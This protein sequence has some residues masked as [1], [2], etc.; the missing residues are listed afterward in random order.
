MLDSNHN[1]TTKKELKTNIGKSLL[2][3]ETSL[4]G[5]EYISNGEVLMV[6]PCAHTKRKWFA[7]VTMENDLIKKVE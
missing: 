2:Y 7:K 6:G 5:D 4:F 3:N 1:Y